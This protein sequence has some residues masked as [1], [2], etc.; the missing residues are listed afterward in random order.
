[1]VMLS[2]DDFKL[3]ELPEPEPEPEPDVVELPVELVPLAVTRPEMSKKR[4]IVV[5]KTLVR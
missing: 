1:M 5:V 4:K 2:A 3:P